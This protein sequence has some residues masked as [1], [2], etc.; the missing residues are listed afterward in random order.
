[1]SDE[2]TTDMSE[3][4][5]AFDPKT[6]FQ[7]SASLPIVKVRNIKSH[8]GD[9]VFRIF[10]KTTND[11]REIGIQHERE[12][13]QCLKSCYLERNRI[14]KELKN[15]SIL[16]DTPSMQ[17]KKN[18]AKRSLGN[19]Y[20]Q[21]TGKLEEI[22]KA[23]FVTKDAKSF[24]LN[25]SEHVVSKRASADKA[26]GKKIVKHNRPFERKLEKEQTQRMNSERQELEMIVRTPLPKTTTENSGN[27]ALDQEGKAYSNS[28]EVKFESEKAL[29]VTAVYKDETK[30]VTRG[31]EIDSA[32]SVKACCSF[33]AIKQL[34]D[35]LG[36]MSEVAVENDKKP[37]RP[38]SFHQFKYKV[39][40]VGTTP[41]L[42]SKTCP[43]LLG[44]VLQ[45][46]GPVRRQKR[47]VKL[48]PATNTKMKLEG[49]AWAQHIETLKNQKSTKSPKVEYDDFKQTMTVTR[50]YLKFRRAIYENCR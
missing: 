19:A 44:Q 48:P 35:R 38:T 5:R 40:H 6:I 21:E 41:L 42:R 26:K 12:Q 14:Y 15:I 39:Q 25:Y 24:A 36:G 32:M 22:G 9:D 23:S 45:P 43:A 50:A 11:V 4:S 27:S 18:L 10:R 37:D 16:R 17:R 31:T 13:N 30:V 8:M 7:N 33:P 28:K 1:M 47:A 3:M 34:E 46:T 49:Q 20:Q 2:A 29:A